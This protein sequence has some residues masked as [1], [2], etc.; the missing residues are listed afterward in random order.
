MSAGGAGERG[1]SDLTD[2]L[3]ES[4]KRTATGWAKL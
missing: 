2:R 3:D 1:E 4:D